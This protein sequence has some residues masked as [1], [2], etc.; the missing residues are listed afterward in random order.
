MIKLLGFKINAFY[1][2]NLNKGT[3]NVSLKK[4]FFDKKNNSFNK[5]NAIFESIFISPYGSYI[6][7]NGSKF[8]SSKKIKYD[9]SRKEVIKGI[10]N[11]I[12]DIFKYY[13]Y[14]S[15]DSKDKNYLV[16]EL[17]ALISNKNI[18][19][20]DKIYNTFTF[21]NDFVGAK[22]KKLKFIKY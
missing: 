20:S 18:K 19:F 17:F 3:I 14:F 6:W 1:I 11:F 5:L 21:E 2:F 16:D 4:S 15:Y 22:L 9:D 10:E 8:Q 12:I 7:L 13:D